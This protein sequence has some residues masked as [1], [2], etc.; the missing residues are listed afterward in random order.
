MDSD[1]INRRFT[2]AYNTVL[3]AYNAATEDDE[4]ALNLCS[5]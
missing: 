3:R 5:Y 1:S 4:L 2:E